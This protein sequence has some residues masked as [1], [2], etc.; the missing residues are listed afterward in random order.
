MCIRDRYE[1]YINPDLTPA[2]AKLAF[3]DRENT[4]QEAQEARA[5]CHRSINSIKRLKW[6]RQSAEPRSVPFSCVRRVNTQ[7]RD[8]DDGVWLCSWRCCLM[9]EVGYL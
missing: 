7:V 5:Q 9:H 8:T 3:E 6:Y 4:A 1:L 2:A